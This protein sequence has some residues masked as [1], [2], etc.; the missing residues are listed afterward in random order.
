MT[1]GY[2]VDDV[3]DDDDDDDDDDKY[4]KLFCFLKVK[5]TCLYTIVS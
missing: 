2:D 4:R 5:Q 1:G 3:D